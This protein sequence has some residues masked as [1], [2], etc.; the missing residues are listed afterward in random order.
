M[1]DINLLLFNYNWGVQKIERDGKRIKMKVVAFFNGF[2]L[3]HF[4]GVERYTYNIAQKLL[5]KGYKVIVVT[6]Q[7]DSKLP[8]EEIVEGIEIYRLPV[9]NIWKER[10]PILHK[11]RVYREMIEKLRAKKIDYFI[12]NTRFYMTSLLG[13]DLAME[14]N[15][16]ALVIEHGSS[17]LTLGSQALD[18]ILN[19]IERFLIG[20]IK[21][22]TQ[23]FY[24]VS[25]ESAAWLSEFDINAK[26][27]LYNAVDINDY[28]KYHTQT[29]TNNKIVISYSGR[30][31]PQMKGVEILLSAFKKVSREFNNLE[32]II[33]GDGPLL[34]PMKKRYE[35]KNIHFLG[36]VNYEKV[37]EIDDSSDIFVLMSRSEGFSTA[38]L[39]AAMLENVIITTPTVGGARD[40][41]PDETYGFIIENS[42]SALIETFK[43]II[44]DKS[45]MDSVKL[46]IS[47]RVLDKFTWEQTAEKFETVF[48]EMED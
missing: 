44:K 16:Q 39:E 10:Y 17:Y 37:M 43:T 3:P 6:S 41:I 5:A 31:I 8:Y 42:E 1:G 29:S 12:V 20:K 4:G 26:G 47:E 7:H 28:H 33:A 18:K 46:R 21:K 23:K 27:V 13:S 22:K 40:I 14:K 36:F 19:Q 38:M 25:K 2:Y 32:L 15:K 24:G 9:W 35:Q 34:L 30:L 45:Q 11:N 48:K